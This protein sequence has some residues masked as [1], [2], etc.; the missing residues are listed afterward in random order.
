[1][2]GHLAVQ[3]Y[4]N[5]IGKRTSKSGLIAKYEREAFV[6]DD[7]EFYEK[8]DSLNKKIPLE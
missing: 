2:A 6:V 3:L 4:Y 1:M 7:D 5:D 8:R